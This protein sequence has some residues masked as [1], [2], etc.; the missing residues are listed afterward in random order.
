[1]KIPF[2]N[3][4][5]ETTIDNTIVAPDNLNE[6]E[7]KY[8]HDNTIDALSHI[9]KNKNTYKYIMD[10]PSFIKFADGANLYVL[11]ELPNTKYEMLGEQLYFVHFPKMY[12]NG[13]ITIF[14]FGINYNHQLN[15]TYIE[16]AKMYDN[17][18]KKYY[19][20]HMFRVDAP[21]E[22]LHNTMSHIH[23]ALFEFVD[24]NR[25]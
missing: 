24:K 2:F 22:K 20:C 25:K 14:V 1:M 3:K 23:Q 18:R 10:Y 12:K 9:Y 6:E 17:D 11:E 8:V 5:T 15:I 19:P 4:K 16:K 13:E 7:K 21:I